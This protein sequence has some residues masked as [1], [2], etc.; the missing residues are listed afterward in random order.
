MPRIA[1]HHPQVTAAIGHGSE[2]GLVMPL[3]LV[4]AFE[5]DSSCVDYYRMSMEARQYS[6]KVVPVERIEVALNQ[7]FFGSHLFNPRF[8]D[9]FSNYFDA[10]NLTPQAYRAPEAVRET[11]LIVWRH[12]ITGRDGAGRAL[13]T[14]RMESEWPTLFRYRGS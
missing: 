14:K 1:G 13:Q 11:L 8:A 7:F 2:P 5:P 9:Y 4:T 10:R 3:D 12:G 6:F